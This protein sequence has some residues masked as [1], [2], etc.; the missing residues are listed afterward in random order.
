MYEVPGRGDIGKVIVERECVT[1]RKP[2]ELVQRSA[3]APQK[4]RAAS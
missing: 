3:R 4:R 1:S 2:A